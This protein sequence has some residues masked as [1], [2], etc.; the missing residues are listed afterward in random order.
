MS[1]WIP[2]SLLSAVAI[3]PEPTTVAIKVAVPK[4]SLANFLRNILLGILFL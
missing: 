3:A 1:N 2:I 4:N